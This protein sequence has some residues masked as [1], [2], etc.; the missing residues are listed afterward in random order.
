VLES[1]L[2][3]VFCDDIREEVGNKRSLM[4]IYHGEMFVQSVPIL[5]PRLCFYINFVSDL[6]IQAGKV[7]IKVVKGADEEELMST[8]VIEPE[9][10]V[11]NE[12]H[13]GVPYL[14]HRLTLAF[15]LS[16]FMI[17]SETVIKV[18]AETDLGKII[19][20]CLRIRLADSQ[21]TKPPSKSSKRK[22]INRPV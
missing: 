15:G 3:T 16:P 8:G 21:L 22:D 6:T 7:V 19:G 18:V 13:L 4:G 10:T 9:Q 5:L 1:R 2:E 14:T 12:N 20:P 17:N 11:T